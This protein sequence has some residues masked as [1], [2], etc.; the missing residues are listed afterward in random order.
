MASSHTAGT[1]AACGIVATML[2]GQAWSHLVWRRGRPEL[3]WRGEA[4]TFAGATL[5][6]L[7]NIAAGVS[8][9]S[10]ALAVALWVFVGRAFFDAWRRRKRRRR[11][12]GSVGYKAAAARAR[13]LARAR[14][15]GA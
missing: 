4:L 8:L 15:V 10:R 5:W 12:R 6:M 2:A 7:A 1:I 9:F 11:A 14:E 13:L 3:Q